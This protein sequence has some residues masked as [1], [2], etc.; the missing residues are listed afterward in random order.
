MTREMLDMKVSDLT[1]D[2]TYRDWI[3]NASE[4]EFGDRYYYTDSQLNRMTDEEL[5]ELEECLMLTGEGS[6]QDWDGTH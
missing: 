5:T 3:H 1:G 2:Y 4:V 6:S